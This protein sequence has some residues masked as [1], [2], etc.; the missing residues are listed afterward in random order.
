M[1]L[2]LY[3]IYLFL[4]VFVAGNITTLQIQHYNIYTFI[5]KEN[6]KNYM[7]ANNK[8]AI[9]STISPMIL[10]VIINLL[11]IFFRPAFMSIT[12]AIFS[13][14]LSIVAL[15]STYIVQ[16]KTQTEMAETGYNEER[17]SFLI[18][19]SWIRTFIS[20]T[21]A[22]MSVAIVMNALA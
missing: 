21:V 13:L 22:V 9:I 5:G 3:A 2:I 10:L 6:F 19:I 1:Q 18:S 16:W 20:I 17:I 12:E 15:I 14:I 8:A 4:A 7:R 11:L